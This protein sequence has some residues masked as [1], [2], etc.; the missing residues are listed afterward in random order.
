MVPLKYLVTT[1]V[2]IAA[3]GVT[4]FYVQRLLRNEPLMG[5]EDALEI[6]RALNTGRA[7]FTF[8]VYVKG[9]PLSVN[10]TL[11]GRHYKL[12]LSRVLVYFRA[13]DAPVFEESLMQA[14]VAWGNGTHAGA[15]SL[16]DVTDDG[17]TVYVKYMAL[18][19][20]ALGSSFCMGQGVEDSGYSLSAQSEGKVE[21]SGVSYEWIGRRI[22][23]VIR[24][25]VRACG[26]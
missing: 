11:D 16:L 24:V 2:L 18:N 22:V 9:L 1:F 4:S 10:V 7:S 8:N 21:A 19:S 25:E 17:L 6:R 3:T 12:T 20:S 26:S 15:V 23:K 14:W 13:R 5:W